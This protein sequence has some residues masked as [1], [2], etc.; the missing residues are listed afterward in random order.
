VTGIDTVDP[1]TAGSVAGSSS[2]SAPSA[3]IGVSL[4][5]RVTASGATVVLPSENDSAAQAGGCVGE[6]D[7]SE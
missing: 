3:K 6:N 1:A 5:K 7:P 4:A 2:G